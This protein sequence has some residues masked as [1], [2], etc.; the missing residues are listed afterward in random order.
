VA[1][2]VLERPARPLIPLELGEVSKL[3]EAR[4]RSD[5]HATHETMMATDGAAIGATRA[6]RTVILTP[7]RVLTSFRV[8]VPAAVA[9]AA[10]TDA[11]I[12]AC[13][14]GTLTTELRPGAKARLD[15]GDGDFYDIDDIDIGPIGSLAASL[16]YRWRLMGVGAPSRVTWTIWRSPHSS[17]VTII[18]DDPYRTLDEAIE[19]SQR[20]PDLAER[21]QRFLVTGMTHDRR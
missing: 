12:V 3:K 20:W 2:A 8:G 14:L 4:C 6:I 21:L 5:H 1:S 13:W 19:I 15:L 7:G 11:S 18:D 10:L 16:R 17:G 9:W